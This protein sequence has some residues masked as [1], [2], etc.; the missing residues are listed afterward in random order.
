MG[1]EHVHVEVAYLMADRNKAD[2]MEG[3]GYC[4]YPSSNLLP[5]IHF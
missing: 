4:G 5:P 2:R 1:Q 3:T